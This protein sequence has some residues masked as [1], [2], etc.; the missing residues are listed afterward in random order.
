MKKIHH[1]LLLILMLLSY[2]ANALHGGTIKGIVVSNEDNELL[3]GVLVQLKAP[4]V[5]AAT[6]EIGGF[7]FSDLPDGEYTLTFSIIGFRSQTI[8]AK[9]A[10]HETT[11]LKIELAPQTLN[12]ENVEI[13]AVKGNPLQTL[14][15]LDIQTRPIQSSQDILRMVP[16]LFIG[17]HAGG[18]KA[19]Q[20]FLR[21][22]DID[23][24]T[25]IALFA[26]GIPVNMV[27]HAHGQGY[28]DLHFLIPELV[29]KV[30]IQKGPYDPHTGN[31]ATA[32]QVRFET[33]GI[34]EDQFVKLEAGQFDTYRMAAAVNLLSGKAAAHGTTAYIAAE[35][36]FSNS[37]FDSPQNFKRSN[38]FGKFR[39]TL[40]DRQVVEVSLSN[41]N[42]SWLASGQIPE[43]AVA[44][45]SI[46]YFGAIDPTE[47]GHTNRSNFNAIHYWAIN[48][49]TLLKNQFYVSKYAFELYS[50]FT[51][52]LNDPENGDQIHQKENRRITGY[53]S[54][55]SYR[56]KWG[57]L[58][59]VLEGGVQMRYDDIK[60]NE[61]SRT[62]N[63]REVTT[64]LA[65]GDVQEI[66]AGAY[67]DWALDL[68]PSLTLHAG[69]RFDQFHYAYNNAL[70]TVFSVTTA[71]KNHWSPK[72][73][74]NWDISRQLQVFI[75]T[76]SGF[77]SNDTRVVTAR[78]AEQ[79]LPTAWGQD[80]GVNIRPLSR[81]LVNVTGWRLGLQQ[82]FVY[83]GD[84]GVVEPGGKTLRY[85]VDLSVRWQLADWLFFD[86]DYTWTH[87]R[88][89]EEEAGAQYLPLAPIR[90]TTGGLTVNKNGFTG[91]LRTRWLGDRPANED[92][93]ATATGYF[94]LDGQ[95]SYAPL[96]KSGKR[97][98]E[99]QI[100]AQNLAN[101]AWKE[102]QFLTESRLQNEPVPVE[103]IHFTPGTPLWVKGG[104]VFKL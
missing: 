35:N 85:G 92:Y 67:A 26:D 62:R 93:S 43:R 44:N 21:G 59:F 75:R 29:Q 81:L 54:S 79:V 23:H 19:E 58:P 24:G 83:V 40:D 39:Q 48:D 47:G 66:N 56:D 88:A 100:S 87:G 36:L 31:F 77:H 65:L 27:S 9:V 12:L 13:R 98:L 4:S 102:T 20:I 104:I 38:I 41:F 17:Q 6:N 103:E 68:L 14:S 2:Q 33:P 61:L 34:L 76:G 50:N 64:A 22:F 84:E 71:A 95:L 45:G 15:Q 1:F 73:S 96:L 69:G 94:L 3:P 16:G 60:G 78:T 25:D 53:T 57:S 89:I 30:D 99:F 86:A 5:V 8:L 11:T 55:I 10:N 52:F 97:P 72:A 74:L 101:T 90:T 46:G 32:G 80:V 28:A 70:D 42:S 7:F 91:S 49:K 37:Y 82:E 51:F 18:G 63:R